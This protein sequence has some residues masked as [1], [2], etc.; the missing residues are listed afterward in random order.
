MSYVAAYQDP[1]FQQCLPRDR[2]WGE[3]SGI[4]FGALLYTD[5]ATGLRAVVPNVWYNQTVETRIRSIEFYA[6]RADESA[7]YKDTEK[8]TWSPGEAIRARADAA[9]LRALAADMRTTRKVLA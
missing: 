6:E 8:H 1:D 3:P 2:D 5:A 4:Y 7:A 9:R